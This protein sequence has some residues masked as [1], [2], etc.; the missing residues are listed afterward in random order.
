[1]EKEYIEQMDFVLYRIV[2]QIC[3]LSRK[4][5]ISTQMEND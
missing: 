2:T 5:F 1:M 3:P 4:F